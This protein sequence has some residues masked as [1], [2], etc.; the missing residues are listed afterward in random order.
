MKRNREYQCDARE[1]RARGVFAGAGIFIVL[2]QSGVG[3]SATRAVRVMVQC[4]AKLAIA[5]RC[6]CR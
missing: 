5:S 3:V 2:C 6:C 4:S 1:D